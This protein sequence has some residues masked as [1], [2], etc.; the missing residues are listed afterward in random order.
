ML[1]RSSEREK[2]NGR[3]IFRSSENSIIDSE[4]MKN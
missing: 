2:K 1:F 3:I 4:N